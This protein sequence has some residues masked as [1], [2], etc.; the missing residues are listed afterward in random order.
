MDKKRL[1]L[2]ILFFLSV[3]VFG[4]LLYYFFFRTVPPEL[5]GVNRNVNGVLPTPVNGNIPVVGNQNVRPGLPGV[6]P[7][8]DLTTPSDVARGGLTKVVDYSDVVVQDFVSNGSG[9]IFYDKQASLF[10]KLEGSNAVPLTD[11]KFFNVEKVTWS[12]GLDRAILEYPDGSNIVYDFKTG[13]QVTL[14]KEMV[15]FSFDSSA[16]QIATK[17]L[18]KTSNENYLMVGSADGSN[19]RLIEPLGPREQ[20]TQVE[21]SPNNQMIAMVRRPIDSDTQGVLPIGLQGENFSEFR[22]SGLKFE[23]K[24]SPTGTALLYNVST[25]ESGYTPELWLTAGDTETLGTSHLDLKLNTRVDKC[26]FN[27]A[28]TSIYCAE[29]TSLPRGSG[30]YPELMQGI[31]DTFYRIDLRSGQKIPLAVPVGSQDGY[32]AQTVSLSSDES[33]LFFVDE[34][35]GRLHSIGL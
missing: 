5:P 10:Y 16:S 14:P 6:S 35:T 26:A 22:V 17:W 28:G 9:T 1:L 34:A 30:L 24:W 27:S 3:A 2:I 33:R 21:Y 8:I 13:K 7:T 31:P 25:A 4:W 32:T 29:P 20:N 12:R 11:K 15:D 23:S 18:G 19:F